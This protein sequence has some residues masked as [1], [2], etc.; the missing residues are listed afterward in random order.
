MSWPVINPRRQCPDHFR[1]ILLGH[2]VRVG[3][4]GMNAV[5]RFIFSSQRNADR[6]NAASSDIDAPA[7]RLNEL[8]EEG[9]RLAQFQQEA[10][11]RFVSSSDAL[12][13]GNP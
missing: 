3:D 6:Y 4:A 2:A 7:K 8:K 10:W 5:G 11:E 9:K 13:W 12:K 1:G